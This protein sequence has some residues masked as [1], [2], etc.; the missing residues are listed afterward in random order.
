MKITILKKSHNK[1]VIN[2]V[3]L[4]D[5][6]AAIKDGLIENAVRKTERFTI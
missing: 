5:V 2:R 4:A 3:E 1:E 6:A